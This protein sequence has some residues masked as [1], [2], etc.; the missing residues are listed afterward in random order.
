M[1]GQ[2]RPD[3]LATLAAAYAEA[4]AF[5]RAVE[6]ARRALRLAEGGENA[7][8]AELLSGQIDDYQAGH[9]YRDPNY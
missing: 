2:R 9:P 1:T 7:G 3:V 4:G 5:D 6:T 8:L